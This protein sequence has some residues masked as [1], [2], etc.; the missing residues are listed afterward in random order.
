MSTRAINLLGF[1]CCATL[2]AYAYYAE[3]VLHLEPCPLCMLQRIGIV[4]MG[5]IFL[6]ASAHNPRSW[7]KQLY[8]AM[9]VLLALATIGVAARHLYV[10]SLP[11][12]TLP[13]CGAPLEVMLRFAP[14]RE[15]LA[16]VLTGSGECSKV[17][18]RLLGLAMP[19]WVL[20]AA[21]G[22]GAIAVWANLK[23]RLPVLR[24]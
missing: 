1:L 6:I 20:M 10:Q 8:G 18:W 24:F 2:M 13:A 3:H 17:D 5:A 7:A 16:K 22:L 23:R 11:P 21:A 15:V 12:G 19:A 9:L 14:W 4:S